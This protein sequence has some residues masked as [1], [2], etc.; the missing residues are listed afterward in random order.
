[1]I[2]ARG[3]SSAGTT[4]LVAGGGSHRS[5]S[6]SSSRRRRRRR[7]DSTAAWPRCREYW[8]D[9][10]TTFPNMISLFLSISQQ[11]TIAIPLPHAVGK[12]K[13]IVRPFVQSYETSGFRQWK[14]KTASFV[15]EESRN[16]RLM[17]RGYHW[18][19]Q[20]T[21]QTD[22]CGWLLLCAYCR[23][24]SNNCNSLNHYLLHGFRRHI[25][26]KKIF[27]WRIVNGDAF[28]VFFLRLILLPVQPS[29]KIRHPQ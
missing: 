28:H 15:R 27:V 11:Q 1:M 17:P 24:E 5:R 18:T 2:R 13:K 21:V 6:C 20:V 8:P 4:G 10:S 7:Y 22:A 3:E 26:I 25:A 23:K 12:V 14:D 29:S 16:E 9:K 19:N